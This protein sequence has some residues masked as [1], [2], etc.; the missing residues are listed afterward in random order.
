MTVAEQLLGKAV[1][2]HQNVWPA[3][4]VDILESHAQ[5]FAGRL[6]QAGL[7]AHVLEAAAAQIAIEQMGHWGEFIGMTVGAQGPF[8]AAPFVLTEVPVEVTGDKQ[9]QLAVAIKVDEAGAG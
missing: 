5:A 1:V 7:G 9:V 2:G 8:T 6:Q 4:A 3:I